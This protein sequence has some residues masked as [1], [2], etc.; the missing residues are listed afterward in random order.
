[1]SLRACSILRSAQSMKLW[2]PK[3]GF[4]LMI[5]TRSTLSITHSSTSSGVAGLNTRPAWQPSAL[6]SCSVR[7]TCALASGWKLIEVGAG[8]GEGQRQR[9]DRLH[10][11][12]HVERHRLPSARTQCGLMAC[13]TTGPMVRFGT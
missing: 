10:H 3:P 5:S 8:L 11:Q 12:V 4:T 7:S 6:I 13:A 2:P 1:M 9:I